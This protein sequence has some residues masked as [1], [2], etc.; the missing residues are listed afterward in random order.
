M[1]IEKLKERVLT[2]LPEAQLEDNK[3][4]VSF[5]IPPDNFRSVVENL[6]NSEET[7]MDYL[8]CLT[9]VDMGKDLVVVYHLSSTK[10]GHEIVLKVKINDRENPAVD[11]ISD[12]YRAADFYERE[13]Y[14]LLGI[15]FNNHSDMRRI[16]LDENWKGYPLRKDYIDEI[17]IVEL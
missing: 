16:F 3:Q 7:A 5:V 2:L 4:F 1:D 9:G 8:F 13:V 17:N 11:T 15:K 6:K 14:D 12:L 10:H